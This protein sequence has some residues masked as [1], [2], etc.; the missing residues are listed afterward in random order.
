[1]CVVVLCSMLLLSG[2]SYAQ[3]V[4]AYGED[5]KDGKKGFSLLDPSRF[6]INHS[7][8]FGMASSSQYSGLQSQSLY[9][10][11]MSYKFSNPVTLDLNFSLPIHSTLNS[12]HNINKE[13]IES[14]DYFKNMPLDATLTWQPSEKFAMQ[15]SVY[16]NTGV[17][18]NHYGRSPF[19]SNY[20]NSSFYGRAK[21]RTSLFDKDEEDEEEE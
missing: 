8:S 9:T 11:M 3:T 21:H 15:L 2:M 5:E 4:E 13:N 1:M 17:Y 18:N 14:L 12:E 16:R 6:S 7:V 19:Y 10:T 20:G